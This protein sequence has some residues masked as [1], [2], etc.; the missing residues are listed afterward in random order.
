MERIIAEYLADKLINDIRSGVILLPEL[1]EAVTSVPLI[2][3]LRSRIRVEDFDRIRA[4]CDSENAAS[5][6]LG[7]ALLRN[8]EHESEVR[9]FLENL[10]ERPDLSFRTRIGLQFQL[11]NYVNLDPSMRKRFL[12]FTLDNW[13]P[14]L[15]NQVAW[16]SGPQGVINFCRQRLT[17]TRF[18]QSKKWLY[19]CV[20]AA[21][22]DSTSARSLLEGYQNDPDP[23]TREVVQ[24]VLKRLPRSE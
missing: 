24:E 22:D 20:V 19:M 2:D 15:D 7:L 5:Q 6:N 14:F 21:S 16:C 18:P 9:S 8:I 23:F 3:Y 17:D 10:W 4:L 13:Q 1:C 11:S 12:A